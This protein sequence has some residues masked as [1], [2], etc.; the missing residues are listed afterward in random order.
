MRKHAC[1]HSALID[2]TVGR[3]DRIHSPSERI[4]PGR[5]SLPGLGQRARSHD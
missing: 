5:R 4:P 1:G 2:W 3:I